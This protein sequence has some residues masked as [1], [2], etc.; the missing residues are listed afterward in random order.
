[1]TSSRIQTCVL[2]LLALLLASCTVEPITNRRQLSLVSADELTALS[3]K[4]YGEFIR[5]HPLSRDTANTE[6]VRRVGRRIQVAVEAYFAEQGQSSRLSGYTWEFNLVESKEVN[7]WCMPGGKVVVYTG[8]LPITRDEAGLAVVLAHEIA[9]AVANHT[10]ERMSQAMLANY[11]LTALGEL[12]AQKP[13]ETRDLFLKVAGLGAQVGALLPYERT[14][15]NSAD[16]LG[17][18]F[19]AM[20]GYDPNAALDFW[21]RMAA[22]GT[23]DATPEL[24]RTHPSDKTRIANIRKLIQAEANRYYKPP[25]R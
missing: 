7:A 6:T 20:A 19:M 13:K 12:L 22:Q 4:E 11:G 23:G 9:H 1:V 8:I 2:S 15:E 25:P 14:Q 3:Y 18:V 17:L 5:S 10:A 16:R 21:Q 24:L